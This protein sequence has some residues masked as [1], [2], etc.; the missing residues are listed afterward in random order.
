MAFLLDSNIVIYSYKAE[1]RYLR[2]LVADSAACISEIS[3]VEI[4][5]YHQLKADEEKYYH[6]M[7]DF[8]NIIDTSKE[9]FDKAIEVRRQFNL[10]LGDSIIAA[11]AIIYGLDLYTRNMGDFLK[12]QSLPCI[13]PIR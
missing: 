1:F 2:N 10:K 3:R 13:D 8:I 11:T 12:I 4:L 6:E 9:I 7:F 5:G